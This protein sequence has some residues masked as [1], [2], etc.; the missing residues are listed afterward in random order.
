MAGYKT[1]GVIKK[2]SRTKRFHR[3]SDQL[4]SLITKILVSNF[5]SWFERFEGFT[6][7]L[8]TFEPLGTSPFSTMST[9]HDYFN[10]NHCDLGDVNVVFIK[11]RHFT[12]FEIRSHIL[13]IQ[14]FLPKLQF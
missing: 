13:Q 14:F 2:F 4:T 5:S 8:G 10:N 9:T 12:N 7:P 3:I 6:N 1:R 11:M